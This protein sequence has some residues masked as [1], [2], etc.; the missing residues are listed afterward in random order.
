M[1]NDKFQRAFGN[2]DPRLIER[3]NKNKH[4][5]SNNR[6]I[7]I[8]AAVLSF[9]LCIGLFTW[10]GRQND[11]QLT[12]PSSTASATVTDLPFVPQGP[13]WVDAGE[14]EDYSQV[15]LSKYLLLSAT[16]P[17][18]VK[19]PQ[20]F[21]RS[22]ID[23]FLMKSISCFLSGRGDANSVYSPIN[24]YFSLAVMAE[25]EEGETREQILELLGA[26]SIEELRK[27][28]YDIWNIYYA[29]NEAST[30]IFANSLWLNEGTEIDEETLQ[31]LRDSYYA[32]VY[33]GDFSSEECALAY[34]AWL[35]ENTDGLVDKLSDVALDPDADMANASAITFNNQ[36]KNKFFVEN[37]TTKVFHSTNGDVEVE[38]MN[39]DIGG[40]Y[41][42][43]GDNFSS[44]KL[45]FQ[46]KGGGMLFI[47]PDENV[48]MDTLLSDSE[49]L[50]FVVNSDDWE[51]RAY[52][53]V[54]LSVPKFEIQSDMELTQGL[55]SLGLDTV[56]IK[57][58]HGAGVII[59]ERGVKASA[60]T[61]NQYY[62]MAPEDEVDFIRDRPFIFVIM[63]DAGLPLF[64]GIVNNP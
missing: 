26:N 39:K 25:L 55:K 33:Q 48:S 1:K 47:M 42:Y 35:N 61:A 57:S 24:V 40:E 54:N 59:D 34:R 52:P 5:R 62:A 13:A 23:D 6:F 64:V 44:V 37:N 58:N 43:W 45:E 10:I 30:C 16:Y 20:S 32:T 4:Y 18:M 7:V 60:Y 19:I 27:N 15:N 46:F 53:Q 11:E 17:E 28:S 38:F 31:I 36:W 8:I 29:K 51:N 2:I 12:P 3:A 41:Y 49:F 22:W 9:S 14:A 63:G 56:N 50:S 21:D